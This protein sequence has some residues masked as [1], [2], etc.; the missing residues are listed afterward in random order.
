ML[1]ANELIFGNLTSYLTMDTSDLRPL[2]LK[3][4]CELSV[5][6]SYCLESSLPTLGLI[7]EACLAKKVL[8]REPL[9]ASMK[10]P[11][12]SMIVSST[13]CHNAWHLTGP[14]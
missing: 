5:K 7:W 9:L 3:T 2:H 12:L 13:S 1:T 11:V 6:D 10:D 8:W 4:N 14:Q